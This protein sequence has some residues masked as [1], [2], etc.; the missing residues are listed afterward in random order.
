MALN[1]NPE[2]VKN[3]RRQ[4]AASKGGKASGEARRAKRGEEANPVAFR[5]DEDIDSDSFPTPTSTKKRKR[6]ASEPKQ[7]QLEDYPG[8][9]TLAFTDF[10]FPT[11]SEPPSSLS[12]PGVLRAN[13]EASNHAR[14]ELTFQ[15]DNLTYY[16]ELTSNPQEN[17]SDFWAHLAR[18][19]REEMKLIPTEPSNQA[20]PLI[21][22]TEDTRDQFLNAM[23]SLFP[24]ILAQHGKLSFKPGNKAFKKTALKTFL[25]RIAHHATEMIKEPKYMEDMLVDK[26]KPTPVNV[27]NTLFKAVN[28]MP[29][30]SQYQTFIYNHLALMTD[31]ME[32]MRRE[33]C[34]YAIA[35]S[36]CAHH[37]NLKVELARNLL[38]FVVDCIGPEA[39]GLTQQ[40]KG[41]EDASDQMYQ[42]E[43]STD[44]PQLTTQL[45]KM[46]P[47]VMSVAARETV[48]EAKASE[49]YQEIWT[50]VEGDYR[51]EYAARCKEEVCQEMRDNPD[52]KAEARVHALNHW[53]L[54]TERSVFKEKEGER[55]VHME[56]EL[57]P[58]MKAEL[59]VEL[60]AELRM[61]LKEELR[62]EMKEELRVELK[63]ELRVELKEEI[64]TELKTELRKLLN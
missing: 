48:T 25:T 51:K 45:S 9:R 31:T 46:P 24:T 7:F 17:Q 30:Q 4:A 8:P 58:K 34:A 11:N 26:S 18:G 64:R 44:H 59:R 43:P 12:V 1:T 29:N 53:K 3:P 50:K 19:V 33:L 14:W 13:P 41:E 36:N 52:I 35:V 23:S 47:I 62:V 28:P 10:T 54:N 20:T 61:E 40:E 5:D 49:I 6:P 56:R 22:A 2:H 60:K 57:R 27:V 16:L 63:E 21:Y 55:K 37:T 39:T 32:L 38:Q 42:P 15:S